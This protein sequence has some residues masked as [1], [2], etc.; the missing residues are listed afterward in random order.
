MRGSSPA[1]AAVHARIRVYCDRKRYPMQARPLSNDGVWLWGHLLEQVEEFLR[2][3]GADPSRSVVLLP[4]AQLMPVARAQWA[5]RHARG[6]MP[7]FETT[8]NWTSQWGAFV[9]QGWDMRFDAAQDLLTARSLLA[10]GGLEGQTYWLAGRLREAALQLAAVASAVP[11]DERLLWQQE[12][13]AQLDAEQQVEALRMEQLVAALSVTWAGLSAYATDVLFGAIAAGQ[14]DALIVWRGFQEDP[15]AT[16][17]AAACEARCPGSS[18]VLEMGGLVTARVLGAGARGASEGR[19]VQLHVAADLEDEAGR[20]AACVQAEVERDAGLVA[21]VDSDR[22]LTRRI[23]AAL[24]GQGLTVR[25]ET[26]WKLSTTLAASQ[27]MALLRACAPRADS[28]VVLEWLKL[29]QGVQVTGTPAQDDAPMVPQG[30]PPSAVQTVEAHLRRHGWA[31]W[32]ARGWWQQWQDPLAPWVLRVQQERESLQAARPLAAWLAD[33]WSVLE[34]TGAAAWLQGDPAGEEVLAA[35]HLN[36][37]AGDLEMGEAAERWSLAEWTDWV[38]EV[39]EGGTFK[40]PYPL[41]EQVVIAPMSQLLAR[42]FAAVVVPGCDAVRLPASPELPGSWTAAQRALLGL[43]DRAAAQAAVRAAW[44]EAL[45]TPGVHLLR[46]QGDGSG[47]SLLPSPLW[48]EVVWMASPAGQAQEEAMRGAQDAGGVAEGLSSVGQGAVHR[49]VE[50]APDPRLLRRVS[51]QAGRMP[52]P[53]GRNL[54]LRELSATAYDTLRHC[55]YQFWARSLLGLREVPELTGE[56]AKRDFGVWLHRLLQ[57]FHERLAEQPAGDALEAEKNRARW[58]SLLDEA[59]ERAQKEL[60]LDDAAFLPFRMA[61]PSVRQAYLDW[62]EQDHATVGATFERGEVQRR[63]SLHDALAACGLDASTVPELAAL[64]LVGTLDRIDCLPAARSGSQ[65]EATHRLIDYK[66]ESAMA[67]RQR[68]GEP[69][70]DTQ[71]AFYAALMAP[72]AVRV[73][74]LNVPERGKAEL[75]EHEDVVALR[76]QLLQGIAQDMGRIA[77]G[78]PLRALGR[79]VRCDYCS[80]RGLC[81]KDFWEESDT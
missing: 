40:P 23:R 11:P 72:E 71:L 21:L 44:H 48:Q 37:E 30:I 19:P 78:A 2:D 22:A 29:A 3:R 67:T 56:V 50:W 65:G 7:R 35:L 10:Q 32:P 27:V 66:T 25:D 17:L 75:H 38:G 57:E 63:L 31:Q 46:S 18:L 36:A 20:A 45:G 64:W 79:G 54:P 15:L 13:R 49:A 70:E 62:M 8:F 16:A 4:Y 39:L 69:A 1:G 47:Q 52:R 80:V 12:R 73:G 42:G 59:A 26:G 6:M 53:Q 33:T 14:V 76:D 9:P 74:Y 68:I 51:V 34:A 58:E 41:R 55:P 61:W 77:R 81:R 28:D 43:P 60:L 5:A 24:E